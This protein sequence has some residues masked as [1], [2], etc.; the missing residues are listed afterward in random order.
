MFSRTG[1]IG[2]VH[3]MRRLIL[4]ACLLLFVTGCSS[5]PEGTTSPGPVPSSS[6]TLPGGLKVISPVILNEDDTTAS[7]VA[8][9]DTVVFNLP[10]PADWSAVITPPDLATFV[11]GSEDSTMVSNPGLYPLKEG[12]VTVVL[13]NSAGRKLQYVITI[14]VPGGDELVEN[15]E[16]AAAASEAFGMTVLGMFEVDAVD[17]IESSGRVARIAE[18]D[19]EDFALTADYNP[20]RLNLIVITGLV[21][22]V[23]VG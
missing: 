14:A 2:I 13:T 16:S 9:L 4:G 3:T 7:V 5:T 1:L 22:S 18:R 20:E 23:C 8:G 6:P 10:D 17:A 15:I 19:G 12:K 21:S 11:A